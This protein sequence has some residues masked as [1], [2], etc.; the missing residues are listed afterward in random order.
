MKGEQQALCFG[1]FMGNAS[2]IDR[3]GFD[4]IQER[5][6]KHE[7]QLIG[8]NSNP[9]ICRLRLVGFEKF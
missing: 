1:F 9:L 5:H 4:G 2:D 7:H 6:V 8:E 3:F